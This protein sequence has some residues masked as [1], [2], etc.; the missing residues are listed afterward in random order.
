MT[1]LSPPLPTAVLARL[2]ESLRD[3]AR[4]SWETAPESVAWIAGRYV[5]GKESET[6]LRLWLECMPRRGRNR[7]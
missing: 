5:A 6:T 4:R 7:A 2:P 1:T 3:L